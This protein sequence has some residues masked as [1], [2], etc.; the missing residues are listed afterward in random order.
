MP[1]NGLR[2]AVHET[3]DDAFFEHLFAVEDR[4]FWFRA[5]NQIIATLVRQVV[6][7]LPPGYRVLEV[8]CGTGNVLRVL[9]EVCANGAVVGLDQS[10]EGLRYAR[11]RTSC[12]L[13][14][15]DARSMSFES[16]FD[17]VGLFD[18]IEHIPDDVRLLRDLHP[19]LK[20][21]SALLITVPAR[22][23]LWSYFDEASHHCRRYEREEL[24][25]KLERAGYRIEYLS[26][27]MATLFPLMWLGRRLASLRKVRAAGEPGDSYELALREL[28]IVPGLND[29]L[30]NLL[31]W[32]RAAVSRRRALPLGASLIALARR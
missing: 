20:P 2:A 22:M 13:I 27:Y 5:R 21:G 25:E 4:H 28:R 1:E 24:R 29:L 3:Y 26:H 6:A 12:A 17:L 32:E 9:E 10:E 30:A 16:P 8:G 7:N 18:V 31:L 23:S 11:R 14:A 19:L 15:G